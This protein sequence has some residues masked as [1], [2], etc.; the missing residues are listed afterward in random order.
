MSSEAIIY[1]VFSSEVA[2]HG[3]IVGVA[4]V[5]T[6]ELISVVV[7]HSLHVLI[8]IFLDKLKRKSSAQADENKKC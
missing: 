6:I 7:I 4:F 1:S 5:F 2:A 8:T 3:F